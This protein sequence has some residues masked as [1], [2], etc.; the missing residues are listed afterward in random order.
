M[1]LREENLKKIESILVKM[2]LWKSGHLKEEM[3]FSSDLKMESIEVVD[4][5]FELETFFKVQIDLRTFMAAGA[6]K[7]ILHKE[8]K[9]SHFLDYLEKNG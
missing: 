8:L 7:E 1:S 9:I 2:K 3:L 4:F 5:V 6:E